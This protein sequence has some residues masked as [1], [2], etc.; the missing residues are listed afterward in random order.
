MALD[1]FSCK[2]LIVMAAASAERQVPLYGGY[3][4]Y[5]PRTPLPRPPGGVLFTLNKMAAGGI[6][7]QIGGGFH[8]YSTDAEWLIPHFEKMLYDNA[9]L[10]PLFLAAY[11][12]TGDPRYAE[13][14]E[15][16][17][18]YVLREMTHATGGFFASQDADSE[19]EEGKYYVWRLAELAALLSEDDLQLCKAYYGITTAGNFINNATISRIQLQQR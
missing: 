7:D 18:D 5:C 14:V 15:E 16:T 13:I 11:Q 1:V 10:P 19:G 3:I 17:L 4:C 2:C 9:L 6:Y 8:R 12:I